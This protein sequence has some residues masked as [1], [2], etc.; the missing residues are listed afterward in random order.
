MI[1]RRRLHRHPIRLSPT[2]LTITPRCGPS[3]YL[4]ITPFDIQTTSSSSPIATRHLP[5]PTFSRSPLDPH[6][7]IPAHCWVQTSKSTPSVHFLDHLGRTTN[8]TAARARVFGLSC[9]TTVVPPSH[10]PPPRNRLQALPHEQQRGT[11]SR[12]R[13][14]S[15]LLSLPFR[16]ACTTTMKRHVQALSMAV[17]ARGPRQ[18]LGSRSW[19]RD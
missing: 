16:G 7:F 5:P 17:A 19:R 9:K 6:Q 8:T 14:T 2:A 10:L 15:R 13:W 3:L 18:F 4:V 12:P 1:T 11:P